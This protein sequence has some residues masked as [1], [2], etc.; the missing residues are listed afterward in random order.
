MSEENKGK[1]SMMVRFL[2]WPIAI[3]GTAFLIAWTGGMFHDKT[4]AGKL[5]P[6]HRGSMSSVRLPRKKA[7]I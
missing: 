7:C 5:D 1:K 4:A 3:A 2:K 6:L